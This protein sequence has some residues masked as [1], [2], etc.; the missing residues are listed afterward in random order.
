MKK[1]ALIFLLPAFALMSCSDDDGYSLDKFWVSMATVENPNNENAFYLRL[2]NN[3]LLW[4]AASNFINYRPQ[5]GQRIIADYTIL[6]DKPAGSPYQHDVK[7]ND[8]YNVLTKSI[9]NITPATQDSIGND[10]I[11]INDMWV[12]GDFLNVEFYYGGY[13]KRHFINLVKD[14]SKEYNDNRV[15][16]ELRHNSYGDANTYRFKGIASFSLTSLVIQPAAT[17]NRID[18]TI[19]VKEQDGSEKTYDYIYDPAN[20]GVGPRQIKRGDFASGN[21]IDVQ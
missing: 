6:N 14:N 3:D 5:N 13:N 12:G 20:K 2:D 7:L 4:T 10:P 15:H 11:G 18:L 16:L 1:Y 17:S 19:H 21:E 9:Y 8:A